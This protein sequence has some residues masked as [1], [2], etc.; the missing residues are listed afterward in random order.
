MKQRKAPLEAG[1][2]QEGFLSEVRLRLDPERWDMHCRL[3]D[4]TV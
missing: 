4:L 3:G 1:E 2:P